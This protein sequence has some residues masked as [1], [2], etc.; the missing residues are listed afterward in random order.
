MNI[1]YRLTP[2]KL[3]IFIKG[4]SFAIADPIK[5]T[6]RYGI[7]TTTSTS[8]I[9]TNNH[10][11]GIPPSLLPVSKKYGACILIKTK[12]KLA[13]NQVY[14]CDCNFAV[15]SGTTVNRSPTSPTSATW[16]MG[17]SPSR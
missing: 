12:K 5:N 9:N 11:N 17:A 3:L 4:V 7:S 16:N 6:R 15:N 14:F 8:S 10:V 1:Y 2:D 13:Q